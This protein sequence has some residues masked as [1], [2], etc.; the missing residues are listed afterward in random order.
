[1]QSDDALRPIFSRFDGGD[2]ILRQ[3]WT[4]P[5][6]Y[7][8][9]SP[10]PHFPSPGTAAHSFVLDEYGKGGVYY[11]SALEGATSAMEVMAVR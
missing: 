7:P 2:A 6:A 8:K 4:S 3:S 5:G 11:P 10:L 9:S 1:M